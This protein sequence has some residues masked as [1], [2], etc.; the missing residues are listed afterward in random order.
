MIDVK[1]LKT[2]YDEIA[3]NIKDRYMNV[4]LDKIV[5][6][7]EERAA[8]LLEVENLRSKRNETA[9]KMKQ[10][11]DNETRQ[12]YI[13]EGKE[14]KEALAEKEAR[15]TVLDEQFKKEVMTIQN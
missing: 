15:L 3:K 6:D 1:E 4:D 5:K 10:K 13:Q 11:L 2:R 7:Q 9:Q 12:L 8:L 14:I